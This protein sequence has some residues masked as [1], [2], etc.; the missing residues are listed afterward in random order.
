MDIKQLVNKL[1]KAISYNYRAD[2]TAPGLTISFVR[3]SYYCSVVRYKNAF[4]KDK[5]VVCK[6]TAASLETALNDLTKQF[7]DLHDEAIDPVQE[8]RNSFT[9]LVR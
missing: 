2:K 4:A 6:S 5:V 7:L 3:N 8:L 9:I 1:T